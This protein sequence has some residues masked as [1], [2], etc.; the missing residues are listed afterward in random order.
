MA[1]WPDLTVIHP[2]REGHKSSKQLQQKYVQ[3]MKKHFSKIYD[4]E[5]AAFS[6]GVH[7]PGTQSINKE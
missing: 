4:N 1:N 5:S 2:I 3:D 6:E 7:L